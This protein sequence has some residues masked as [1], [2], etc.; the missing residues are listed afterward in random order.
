[1]L[2]WVIDELITICVQVE[3]RTNQNKAESA[4]LAHLSFES[5]LVDVQLNYWWITTRTSILMTNL[6]QGSTKKKEDKQ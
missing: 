2:K 4:Y 6:L 1:M 3:G 5:H